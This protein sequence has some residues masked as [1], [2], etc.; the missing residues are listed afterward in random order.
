M[1]YLNETDIQ[2]RVTLLACYVGNLG[3]KV[4]EDFENGLNCANNNLNTLKIINSYLDI[5]LKYIPIDE[6]TI[7]NPNCITEEEAQHIFDILSNLTNIKF[8]PINTTYIIN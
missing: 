1:R 5:I 4:K 8:K 7:E 6:N 2:A 3:K